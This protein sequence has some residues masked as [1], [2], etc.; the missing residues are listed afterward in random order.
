MS[1]SPYVC[2]GVLSVGGFLVRNLGLWMYIASFDQRNWFFMSL[3]CESIFVMI[4]ETIWTYFGTV[5]FLN[6]FKSLA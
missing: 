3:R 2:W 6:W 5:V 1:A 4:L